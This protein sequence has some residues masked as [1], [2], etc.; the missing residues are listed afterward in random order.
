MN[1]KVSDT[2]P[3]VPAATVSGV[4]ILQGLVKRLKAG[5]GDQLYQLGPELDGFEIGPGLLSGLAA[6]PGV[7]KTALSGQLAFECLEFNPS[8]RVYVAN[9]ESGF[10]SLLKRELTGRTSVPAKAIR[11]ADLTDSQIAE[12][13]AAAAEIE[14]LAEDRLQVLRIVDCKPEGLARLRHEC[15]PGFLILDYLQKFIGHGRD[16]RQAVN[17]LMAGLRIMA[18][19]GWGILCLSATARTSGK[20]GSNHNGSQLTLASFKESGEI[21]FNL[22]SAYLLRDRGAVDEANQGV[23]NVTL[24]CVKNRHGERGETDLV[25]NMP[26]MRFETP[27]PQPFDFGGEYDG[28]A[29]EFVGDQAWKQAR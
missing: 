5:D 2:A 28:A 12:I 18:S 16:T 4:E 26:R 13:E 23:R 6:G 25:F 19:E 10:E 20:G 27:T 17:E 15:E 1:V 9:A 22:D 8:V 7:G 14:S 11:S 21:E 3:D 24:D 29:V